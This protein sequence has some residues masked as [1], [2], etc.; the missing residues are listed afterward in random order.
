LL[1]KHLRASVIQ[2]GGLS[3]WSLTVDS[4][5]ELDGLDMHGIDADAMPPVAAGDRCG[6][7][8]DE[9]DSEIEIDRA[10]SADEEITAALLGQIEQSIAHQLQ[11]LSSADARRSALAQV[12]HVV[13]HYESVDRTMTRPKLY[14]VSQ[15]ASRGARSS[16]ATAF[17][18]AKGRGRPTSARRPS[19]APVL[20]VADQCAALSAALTT[21]TAA[22][23]GTNSQSS[24]A[25]SRSSSSAAGP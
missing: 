13:S 4:W 17:V 9:D 23:A 19:R 5:R 24:S 3:V 1:C 15:F 21:S 25:V 7:D 11:S 12:R 18:T 16:S 20:S 10:R 8:S 2:A 6:D 14:T 22:V